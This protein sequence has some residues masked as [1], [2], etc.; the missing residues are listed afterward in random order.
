PISMGLLTGALV[1]I[2]AG[3]LSID[4]AYRSIDWKT[5]FLLAGLIPLGTAMIN[6]GTAALIAG[7]VLPL[8]GDSHPMLLFIGIG[9]LATLFTLIMSN[10]GAVV[11]LVPIALLVGAQT[12]IDPRGL[13]LLVGLCASNSFLLPTHQ[14]N[15]FLMSSGGYRTRDYLKAGSI[16]TVLFLIIVSGWIYMVFV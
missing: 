10:L 4:E 6:T 12:G 2:L 15:A 13:A 8:I 3:V 14:V 7:T 5:V 11:I 16:L 1:M 9:A